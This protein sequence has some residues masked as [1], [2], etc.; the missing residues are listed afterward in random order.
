MEIL[1]QE[2]MTTVWNQI[3]F[4]YLASTC[5]GENRTKK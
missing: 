4:V 3:Q 5:D 2:Q 1:L